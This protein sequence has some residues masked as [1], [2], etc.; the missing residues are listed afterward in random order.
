MDVQRVA[1]LCLGLYGL[2][3]RKPSEEVV[4]QLVLSFV[5]G[6]S[7]LSFLAGEGLIDLL[8]CNG[9]Q[10]VDKVIAQ[11][12]LSQVQDSRV[13]LIA[14][15]CYKDCDANLRVLDLLLA[16]LGSGVLLKTMDPDEDQSIRASLGEGF[17]KILL[18]SENYPS[19][20]AFLRSLTLV[21]LVNMYV[22]EENHELQR[23]NRIT[24]LK[25][26][27][28]MPFRLFSSSC[29]VFCVFLAPLLTG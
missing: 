26:L 20:P 18:L 8:M 7:A 17:A 19:I 15:L 14:D 12:V 27:S 2:L 29:H 28:F 25:I 22:S 11:D 10:E 24:F 4:N 21:K 9:L 23:Y 1:I 16:G 6:P 13:H 3:E 5:N